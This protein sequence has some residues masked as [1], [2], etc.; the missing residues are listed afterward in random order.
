MEDNL[1]CLQNSHTVMFQRSF[2]ILF[3]KCV[4]FFLFIV[5]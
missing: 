1:T 3:E 4:K 2:K 5:N